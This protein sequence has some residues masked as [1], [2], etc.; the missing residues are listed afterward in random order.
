MA[1]AM[2]AKGKDGLLTGLIDLDTD[3]LRVVFTDHTDD[4]PVP[5]TDEDLDD[6]DDAS[7]SVGTTAALTTKSVTSGVFDADDATAS[8]V[9][10]D[11]FDSITLYYHTGTAATS[12]LIAYWDTGTGLPCTPN[13]GDITVQWDSGANKIFAWNAA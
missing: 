8:T 10:G 3:E 7:A 11:A 6:I 1:N 12:L 13:G 5:A 4:T 2:Y 9:S